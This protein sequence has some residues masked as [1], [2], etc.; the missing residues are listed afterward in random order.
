MIRNTLRLVVFAVLM[1]GGS[2]AADNPD[3]ETFLAEQ[4]DQMV[5]NVHVVY[6]WDPACGPDPE[7][8]PLERDG[9]VIDVSFDQ[10]LDVDPHVH[11]TW[12]NG[13]M[14]E[15][16]SYDLTVTPDGEDPYVLHDALL[17]AGTAPTE[18]AGTDSDADSDSDGDA[19]DNDGG[20]GGDGGCSHV[21]GPVPRSS[22]GWMIPLILALLS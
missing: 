10:T 4:P 7:L 22:G 21:P 8:G 15:V 3:C 5:T 20:G 18:D 16:H 1:V 9:E 14:P 2:A 11:D 19:D 6:T 17:V 13:V 12:D